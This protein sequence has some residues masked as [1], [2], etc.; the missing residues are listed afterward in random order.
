MVATKETTPPNSRRFGER[1]G[2]GLHQIL[3]VTFSGAEG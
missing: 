1:Q 3:S 2:W